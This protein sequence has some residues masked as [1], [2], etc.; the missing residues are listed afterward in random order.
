MLLERLVGLHGQYIEH[1]AVYTNFF[2]IIAIG[3]YVLA[4]LNKRKHYY[5]GQMSYV[6]GVQTGLIMT[7]FIVLL[8]PVA[9]Y[10]TH[11]VITP[12]YFNNVAELAVSS[13]QLTEAEAKAYFSVSH[14]IQL[15]MIMAAVMGLV[16]SLV[17]A[18]FTR[19]R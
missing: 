6:Q 9:Q 15:S 2:A 8:V 13:G 14:Y 12:D 4:L 19:S 18:F 10:L 11:N 5:G 17:V 16:T 3:I 1:H 7:L